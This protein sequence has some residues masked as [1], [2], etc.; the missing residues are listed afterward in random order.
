MKQ[1]FLSYPTEEFWNAQIR[2]MSDC[3]LQARAL[4]QGAWLSAS[5]W[6]W[7][8]SIEE[9]A[10]S[11][12]LEDREKNIDHAFFV[13]MAGQLDSDL[14][15]EMTRQLTTLARLGARLRVGAPAVIGP[16]KEDL[17]RL[18]LTD[19]GIAG[20]AAA[21][22]SLSSDARS[23]ADKA[24]ARLADAYDE[25][26]VIA[27]LAAAALLYHRTERPLV[28]LAAF[29][30]ALNTPATMDW[31]AGFRFLGQAFVGRDADTG[32]W[33]LRTLL[34]NDVDKSFFETAVMRLYLM[35]LL[36]IVWSNFVSLRPEDKD[37]KSVV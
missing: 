13:T 14:V 6:Q 15:D 29:L 7:L 17:T 18:D 8:I 5:L 22:G 35:L 27:E 1:F 16:G 9:E 28:N 30:K 20:V 4:F 32:Q 3:A 24:L 12:S 36:Y 19:D 21:M 25:L 33:T 11:F 34:T 31:V 10:R 37:R 23:D 2:R 26:A